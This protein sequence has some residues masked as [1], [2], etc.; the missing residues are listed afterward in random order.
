MSNTPLFCK[1]LLVLSRLPQ[2]AV[3][4][5]VGN[6]QYGESFWKPTK[7]GSFK[8]WLLLGTSRLPQFAAEKC[9]EKQQNGEQIQ[10][11]TNWGSFISIKIG[12]P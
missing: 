3:Y 10:N 5:Y 12:F 4:K 7:W 1:E 2:F 11:P 8:S 9:I 6:S